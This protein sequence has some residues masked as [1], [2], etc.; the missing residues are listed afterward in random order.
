L[1][2]RNLLHLLVAVKYFSILKLMN[3]NPV[4]NLLED[5]VWYSVI[6]KYLAD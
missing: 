4:Q 3:Q 1:Q 5:V 6:H 2:V